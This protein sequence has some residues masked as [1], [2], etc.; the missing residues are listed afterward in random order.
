MGSR[1][2][3]AH[4]A[5]RND[6]PVPVGQASLARHVAVAV[7]L[8]DEPLARQRRLHASSSG[9]RDKHTALYSA[10]RIILIGHCFRSVAVLIAL[11]LEPCGALQCAGIIH[12]CIP[13]RDLTFIMDLGGDSLTFSFL[14]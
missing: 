4:D 9:P 2:R 8:A 11:S 12:L 7:A 3:L 1:D 10:V 14:S 6:D 13:V 5:H